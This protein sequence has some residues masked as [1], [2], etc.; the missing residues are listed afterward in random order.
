MNDLKLRLD[1]AKSIVAEIETKL[2]AE[3]Y[4]TLALTVAQSLTVGDSECE[5][6]P[7]DLCVYAQYEECI[8]CGQPSK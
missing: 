3:E 7:I 1:A 5:E 8:Y 2:K 4:K 6:S